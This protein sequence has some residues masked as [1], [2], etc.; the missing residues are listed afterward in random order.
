VGKRGNDSYIFSHVS[1]HFDLFSDPTTRTVDLMFADAEFDP[2]FFDDEDGDFVLDVSDHCPG[3]PYGVEV[4]TLGCPLDGDQDGIPNYLDQELDTPPGAWVNELGE[5]VTGAEFEAVLLQREQAM[6]REN[7]EAYLD[8]IRSAYQVG[9]SV[10]IPDRFKSL[11][12]NEDGYISFDELLKTIDQY[13]D[14]QLDL[15]LEELRQVN[16]F[17]F[18]Q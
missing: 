7:V 5:T 11:D 3:T 18:S 12:E 8:M 14:Y 15:S 13:F 4:D 1:L 17:F 2:L 9:S 10:V 16:E 6:P